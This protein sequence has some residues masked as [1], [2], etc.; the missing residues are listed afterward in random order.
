VP[1][2]L[3]D[4][5]ELRDDAFLGG[6]TEG[7]T[8]DDGK[9]NF[10]LVLA[11]SVDPGEAWAPMGC[12]PPQGWKAGGVRRGVRGTTFY[13][14]SPV[15]GPSRVAER[16]TI[17]SDRTVSKSAS[18]QGRISVGIGLLEAELG[19]KL[20]ETVTTSF[21]EQQTFDLPAG[22]AVQAKA[23]F[24]F[25]ETDFQRAAFGG[26]NCR[27]FEESGT[28]LTPTSYAIVITRA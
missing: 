16:I 12:P 8:V 17:E 26:P 6:L 25:T 2:Y 11:D 21:R 27:P 9:D 20:Q 24:I 3:P 4:G 13:P 18:I 7:P 10:S 23:Q 1:Y 28:V 22:E 5:T 14:V 19:V 15:Y